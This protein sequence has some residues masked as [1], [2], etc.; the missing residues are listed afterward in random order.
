M[1]WI[2][3]ENQLPKDE[4]WCWIYVSDDYVERAVY[5]ADLGV[6]MINMSFYTINAPEVEFWQP[7]Y[8]PEPP[9]SKIKGHM[10]V[11]KEYL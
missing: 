9:F 2:K 10:C 4:Q 11:E 6:W 8:T 3:S 7:Y 5:A 1:A